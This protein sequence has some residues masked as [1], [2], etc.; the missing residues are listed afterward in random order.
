MLWIPKRDHPISGSASHGGMTMVV[1]YGSG[2]ANLNRYVFELPC[3]TGDG[4]LGS[5]NIVEA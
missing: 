3:E 4:L 5:N 1:D 2:Y